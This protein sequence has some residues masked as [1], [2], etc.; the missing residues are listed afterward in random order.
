MNLLY[1]VSQNIMKIGVEAFFRGEICGYENLPKEGGFIIA[2]NH[3][4]LLDPPIVG[5]NIPQEIAFFARKTL[6]KKGFASWWLDG[7]G[8]I[9]VDRD[10]GSDVTAIKR[11]IQSLR[12]G[13]AVILFPEGTRSK[14]GK[15][16]QAKPGIGMMACKM[17]VPVIPTRIFGSFDALGRDSS[18][19]IGT[20]VSVRFGVP[21][22]PS[23]FDHPSDGKL[24]YP[25]AADRIMASI[26]AL[27]RPK[28][29]VI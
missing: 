2:C 3:E 14:D 28:E 15:L 23:E 19:K 12:S 24:R 8:T 26:A 29:K 4:S 5:S 7:V 13:K 25:N 27:S 9:P 21:L 6:W 11:V 22:C 20:A 16:Q 1:K 17:Q 10:G 18:L